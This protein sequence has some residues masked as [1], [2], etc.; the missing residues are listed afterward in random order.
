MVELVVDQHHLSAAGYTPTLMPTERYY[1]MYNIH[2]IEIILLTI[3]NCSNRFPK[4]PEL[5]CLRIRWPQYPASPGWEKLSCSLW[6]GRS[7]CRRRCGP[8]IFVTEL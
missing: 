4:E 7:T 8:E 5:L 1:N 6:M 2:E 3:S